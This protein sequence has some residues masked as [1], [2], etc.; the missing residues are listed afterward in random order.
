M[1]HQSQQI[2]CS[3][4]KNYLDN[5]LKA[6]DDPSTIV[7]QHVTA[8]DGTIKIV[9]LDTSGIAIVKNKP[10]AAEQQHPINEA[11]SKV[12]EVDMFL[13]FDS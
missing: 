9:Q 11:L 8:P 7:V 6:K 2:N 13:L 4:I 12:L 3:S 10:T 1:G 5:C